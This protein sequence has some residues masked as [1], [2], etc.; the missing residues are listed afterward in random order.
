MRTTVT[1]TLT[2]DTNTIPQAKENMGKMLTEIAESAVKYGVITVDS[3]SSQGKYVIKTEE[4]D[5][6]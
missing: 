1:I 2:T 4:T 5:P 3:F 6:K